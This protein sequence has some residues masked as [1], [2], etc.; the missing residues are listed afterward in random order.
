MVSR[1]RVLFLSGLGVSGAA[2]YGLYRMNH[3]LP[4]RDPAAEG[5]FRERQDRLLRPNGIVAVSHFVETSNPLLQVHVIQAGDGQPLLFVHGGN[6]VAAAWTPLLARLQNRFRLYAPDRPGCGLTTKFN[7]T[8]VNLRQHA[9]D[10]LTSTMDALGLEQATFVG[11]SMGGYFSLVFSLAEPARVSK[12]V[13]IGEPAGS[14]G[15]I[16]FSHRLIGTRGVN[17]LLYATALKPAPGAAR[18]AHER[19]LIAD[20]NRVSREYLEFMDAAAAIPGALE[21]WLTMV[22]TASAIPGAGVF[23]RQSVLTHA[24]R[25][26]LNKVRCPTLFLWGKKDAFGPPSLGH[27]M[28]ELIPRAVCVTVPD[29][30]HAVWLDQPD[31]CAREIESFVL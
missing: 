16:R 2:G 17:S 18:N 26:E 5:R 28:A 12:L 8:G 14:P 25:P 3:D 31:I 4:P 10:F 6:S 30:G 29:A 1:R 13:L 27:E 23:S 11:N 9:V 24:L 22:E 15:A 20:I 19:M 7:Y 21:S